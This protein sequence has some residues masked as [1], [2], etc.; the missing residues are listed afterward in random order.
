MR[1]EKLVG[2][3]VKW[4]EERVQ[5][6]KRKKNDN[7]KKERYSRFVREEK[8]FGERYVIELTE[9]SWKEIRMKKGKEKVKKRF[10]TCKIG[11]K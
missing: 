10:K 4:F 1:D 9:I 7:E 6:S 5:E 11:K 8:Q 2:S 3:E